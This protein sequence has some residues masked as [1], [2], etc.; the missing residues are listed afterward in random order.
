MVPS[1]IYIFIYILCVCVVLKLAS[2]LL[3]NK[4]PADSSSENFSEFNMLL[5]KTCRWE[6]MPFIYVIP[7]T[8][9][10][11]TAFRLIELQFNNLNN[12]SAVAPGKNW[13][14]VN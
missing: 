3:C 4:A 9:A 7:C 11:K 14:L 10:H 12:N 2:P 13:K 1:N 6:H 5:Q 8:S